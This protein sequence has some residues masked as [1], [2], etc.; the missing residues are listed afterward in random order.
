MP[1]QGEQVGI[2][3]IVGLAEGRTL[4]NLQGN[5]WVVQA[6]LGTPGEE[7]LAQPRLR[8]VGFVL[9]LQPAG[10]IH[11]DYLCSCDIWTAIHWG[12]VVGMLGTGSYHR[13]W[14]HLI[15]RNAASGLLMVGAGAPSLGSN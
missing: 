4:D 6:F 11:K 9:F 1:G 7:T 5:M 2:V 3:R 13:T 15:Y 14:C 12:L 10:C 8:C